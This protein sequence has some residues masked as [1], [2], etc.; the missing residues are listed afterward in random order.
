MIDMIGIQ[1]WTVKTFG[2]KISVHLSMHFEPFTE[3]IL[4]AKVI[5]IA[6]RDPGDLPSRLLQKGVL[7]GPAG[8]VF[9]G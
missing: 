2:N 6:M 5:E 8:L 4:A 1:T 9:D 3:L 7:V